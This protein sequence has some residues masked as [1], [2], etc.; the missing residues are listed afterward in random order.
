MYKAEV[1]IKSKSGL[2]ARPASVFVKEAGK[3]N[4][5]IKVIKDG[6]EYVAKS[7]IGILSMAA[8]KGDILTILAEG[9]DEKVAVEALVQ[10]VESDFGDL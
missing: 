1:S 5:M 3:Y 2:H 6:N 9:C 8:A 7:I 4:S 10:L